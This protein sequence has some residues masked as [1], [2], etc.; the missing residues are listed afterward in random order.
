MRDISIVISKMQVSHLH[1]PVASQA[2]GRGFKSRRPLQQNQ[3]IVRGLQ[4]AL[5][6]PIRPNRERC[7]HESTALTRNPP[8]LRFR[9]GE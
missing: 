1:R 4:P 3:G 5:T 2:E 6:R 8:T 7:G 9:E